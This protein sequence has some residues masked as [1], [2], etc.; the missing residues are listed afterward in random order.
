M[1]TYFDTSALIPLVVEEAGTEKATVVWAMATQCVS[2]ALIEVESFAA[3]AAAER[4]GRFSGDNRQALEDS[5]TELF[6]VM[7]RVLPSRELIREDSVLAREESLR[8]YDAMHLAT[9]LSIALGVSGTSGRDESMVFASGDAALLA[10]AHR[11]GLTVVDTSE[12][13]AG[14][15]DM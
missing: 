7:T 12:S 6:A 2:S 5:V 8:G 14:H 3:L 10:A 9:A 11:R 1:V 15:Q 13:I 4:G